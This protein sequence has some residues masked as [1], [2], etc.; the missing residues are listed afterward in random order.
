MVKESIMPAYPW[1]FTIKKE[2][3]K[4]RCRGQCACRIPEG[5]AG[6]VVATK[7]ALYLVAYLQSLKQTKLPDG[8]AAPEFLYKRERKANRHQLKT[9]ELDGAST[10]YCQLPKLPPG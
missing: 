4:R 3:A 10:L 7:E 5:K 9:K 2:A 1:M 8:K 6:K